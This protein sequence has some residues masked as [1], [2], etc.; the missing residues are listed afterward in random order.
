M[1]LVSDVY[2]PQ[3]D[4]RTP[5]ILVRIPF[6]RGFKN[7][8]AAEVIARFRATR[9]YTVVIQGT[10]GRFKSGGAYYPLL[11]GRPQRNHR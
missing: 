11:H 9:G 2:R 3:T 6:S 1:R 8:P 5:T 7:D 4:G 10:R